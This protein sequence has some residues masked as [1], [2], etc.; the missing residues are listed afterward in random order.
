[1]STSGNLVGSLFDSSIQADADGKVT[2]D[3]DLVVE[4]TTT[5]IETV[6]LKVEDKLIEL[7]NGTSG[8]PSGDGGIILERGSSANASL[9]WDE[10]A[11]TW[12]VSTTSATGSSSG[13][14]TLTDA[15]LKA[16]AITASGDISTTGE[17]KTAKVSFTDG[18]DAIVIVDGGGITASVSLTLASGSTVT[19]IKDE[20]NMA[21]DSATSLVTQQSVKAY[22]DSTVTAQDLD[23]TVDGSGAIAIDLDSEALNFVSGE[24]VDV[25]SSG[26]DITIAGED[27]TT[28]NKGVASFSSDNF[29]V[30]SGAVTIKSGGVDLAA[31][32]TGTLPVGNG[33]TGATSLTDGGVLLGSGSSAVT[34]TA[35]L[36]NGQLL[37][38][39]GSGDPTVAALTAGTGI[40]VTNGSGSITIAADVS[41]FMA[42]GSNNRVVTATGTD[43]MNAESALTFDGTTL[44]V[45][46]DVTTTTNHTTVGAHIDYDATGIIASGQ[47]GNNVGLDLD[48]N[49]NSPTMVGTV[50]NTGLDIDLTGGT[51][52]TQTN[53]GIDVNVTGA[54]T[55]YAAVLNGGNVGIGTSTPL[56]PLHVAGAAPYQAL[57]N[58]AAENGEGECE[59]RILFAD[60]TGTALAQIEGSHSGT[61]DDTKG[62]LNLFTH[63]GSALTAA[64]TI[65]DTQLST[66]AGDVVV[67]GTNPKLT[68]GDAGAEDTMLV[69]DGNAEDFRIGIDDGTDTL[70]IGKG[71]AHGTDAIIKIAASTNLTMLLNS[72]V[73]DGE[74]SGNVALFQ[75]GE[76]LTAGEVVYFKSDGKVHKAV[77]TASAT[78][79]CTA[80]CVATVSANAMGPFLLEGFARFDS[81]FPT[82]TVGGALFTPEAETSSKNVPEQTA[83][84]TDGDFVQVIGYAVST[85]AVYFKPDSTVIEVA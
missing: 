34:A 65:D 11:D 66:F 75:A 38:G 50:N 25:S 47:T 77:A 20:D 85:D 19:A 17:I 33:G 26:N 72:A 1:M 59:S 41:D 57:Q 23:V 45:D 24:G 21:S 74:Y 51:S 64:L 27:A 8:T 3:G 6:N 67:G 10:S 56:T 71:S 14:L 80:M 82:W 69:F 32:V 49:S 9:I 29:A 78:S 54:D 83:P 36:T 61:A 60:H 84:D 46:S 35:V 30:S 55:N 58:T 42:N 7:G 40:D 22:V 31:E 37:I 63:T 68:I 16:A 28:S 62:K 39:D 43:A 18:D 44:L 15:A 73:A 2:I 13:D 79:R 76:D 52:G 4:G 53:I 12:V 48:I 81:E 5:S 70:E